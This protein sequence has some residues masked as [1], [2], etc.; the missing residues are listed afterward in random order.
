MSSNLLGIIVQQG[1]KASQWTIPSR[2]SASKSSSTGWKQPRCQ[3]A[4]SPSSCRPGKTS[5]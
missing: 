5:L 3:A 1:C 2:S 4:W